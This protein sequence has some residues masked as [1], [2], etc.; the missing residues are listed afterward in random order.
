MALLYAE[1]G[2][3]A[4]QSLLDG[5][6]N[7]TENSSGIS[8]LLGSEAA[9]GQT[10]NKESPSCVPLTGGSCLA[11]HENASARKPS[12]A[13]TQEGT[14]RSK[15]RRARKR[16]LVKSAVHISGGVCRCSKTEWGCDYEQELGSAFCIYCRPST[17]SSHQCA[18]P[19][20]ACNSSGS[21]LADTDEDALSQVQHR[22]HNVL[23]EISERK[24]CHSCQF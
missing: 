5:K 24:T 12:K 13:T 14:Q 15:Q 23:H 9:R 20:R 8:L 6:D 21:D 10:D 11:E 16:T 1:Q 2:K 4:A 19:C 17:N 7:I 3:A 22:S 18:C